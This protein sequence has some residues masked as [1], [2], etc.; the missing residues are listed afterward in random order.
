[1]IVVAQEQY[2][3]RVQSQMLSDPKLFWSYAKSK[4]GRRSPQKVLKD[5]EVLSGKQCVEEFAQYFYSVYRVEPEP[6]L[7][8]DAA[9]SKA[10]SGG[11]AVRVHLDQLE[12]VD[13]LAL[14]VR[15]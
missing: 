2:R 8:V 9:V 11:G 3:N 1:M 10:G 4:R 13:I 6:V 7:D 12:L 14:D 5:G 15:Q